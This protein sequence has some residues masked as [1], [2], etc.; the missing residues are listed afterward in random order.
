MVLTG[1]LRI[2]GNDIQASDGNTNITLT[3]NTLTTFAGDIQ[4]NGNNILSS[5]A[6]SAM[7]LS[8]IT[9][10]N[11]N[12]NFDGNI[13]KGVIRSATAEAAGDIYLLASGSPSS[14]R[15]ISI[16]NSLDTTKRPTAVLRAYGG[17]GTAAR[18]QIITEV[19]R[20][21]AASPTAIQSGDRM[22]ELV[23]QGYNG[24]DW[25]GDVVFNTPF[26]LRGAATENWVGGAT[27]ANWRAG[28]AFQAVAT[29]S[30]V[31]YTTNA[32]NTIINHGPNTA[33]YVSDSWTFKTRS[34]GSGGTNTNQLTIDSSGN[35]VV[36][37]DLRVN[38]NDILASDGNTNISL[39]SNTLTAFA[40]D[41]RI[42]GNDIQGSGGSSAI[43]LTSGNTNTT[44][45]GDSTR[46]NNA[47]GTNFIKVEDQGGKIALS[48]NQTRATSG[49]DFATGNWVTQRSVDGINYTPTLNNDVIGEF[50]FNGNAYTSTS[51]GVPGGPGG[52]VVVAATENW[53]SIANG[54]KMSFLA[55]KQGTLDSY[56]VFTANPV[57]SL[58]TSDSFTFQTTAASPVTLATVNSTAATFAQPVG[59]PVKTAVQ[60]NAITGAVGRM[61]C[62]SDSAS[63]AHPNGMMAFWDTTNARWSYI[64]DNSAV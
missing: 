51:P 8:P 46:I 56:S 29:A 44:I 37:G 7:T 27:P 53:S 63:G 14:G 2:N 59:L 43:T 33:T 18:A 49:S 58:F 39:T 31:A 3:S 50:K 21:T 16:D 11:S 54:T 6:T 22:A 41:V 30:G 1:D 38:G 12:T 10:F 9:G 32:V 4:V 62:V 57:A 60:W 40:G 64:H 36:T 25:S 34:S 19:A 61:V 28:T 20:G 42:N 48:I 55:I 17:V 45:F 13:V 15:G 5:G 24:S 35:V 23:A 47:A 26:A 52:N